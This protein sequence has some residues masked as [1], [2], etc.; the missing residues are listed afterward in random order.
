MAEPVYKKI[1]DLDVLST[2]LDGNET[3]PIVKSGKT[4]KRSWANLFGSGW[5][6]SLLA[7]FSAFVA[8]DALHA[9]DADTLEGESKDVLHAAA[10]LTGAL[11]LAVIPAQLT[12]KNAATATYANT[13]GSAPANGGTS[14]ACSGNAATATTATNALA[15]SGNAAT[16]TLATNASNAH[17]Y[18]GVSPDGMTV[19]GGVIYA[20]IAATG[21]IPNIG[22]RML[23][24]GGYYNNS[25]SETIP[26]LYAE[27]YSATGIHLVFRGRNDTFIASVVSGDSTVTHPWRI[28]W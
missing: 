16:A 11:N 1:T 22:D 3:L 8:P 10:N 27:R 19:T 28:A 5:I 17:V 24:T 7:A 20:A 13:A 9:T 26:A 2:A 6:T 25:D 15:C 4:Y 14:A 12:G 21:A 18:H 23:I